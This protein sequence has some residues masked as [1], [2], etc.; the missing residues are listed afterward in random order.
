MGHMGIFFMVWGLRCRAS[1][2]K[3]PKAIFYLLKV[4]YRVRQ[5]FV[6]QPYEAPSLPGVSGRG[7]VVGL[8]VGISGVTNWLIWVSGVLAII[9]G[10]AITPFYTTPSRFPAPTDF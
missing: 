7:L 6:H 3:I 8:I 2:Y 10:S 9:M 5:N 1:H 4:D